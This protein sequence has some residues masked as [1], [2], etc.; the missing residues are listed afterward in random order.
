MKNRKSKFSNYNDQIANRVQI[1]FAIKVNFV[2]ITIWNGN[3]LQS[4]KNEHAQFYW[5]GLVECILWIEFVEWVKC[6]VRVMCVMWV[7]WAYYAKTSE[8]EIGAQVLSI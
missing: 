8:N 3:I 6:V 5:S 7:D 4:F 2:H 1:L